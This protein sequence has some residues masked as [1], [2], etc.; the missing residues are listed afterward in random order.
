MSDGSPKARNSAYREQ[1]YVPI[2]WWVQATMFLAT[3]WIAFI[4]ATPAWVAWS[5]TA[6]SVFVTAAMLAN[7]GSARITVEGDV[8][9][10]GTARIDLRF[11]GEPEVLDAEQTRWAA[12]RD[13]DVRAYLL[14]RPYMKLSVRVPIN[15]PRDPAPYW[16]LGSRRPGQLAAVLAARAAALD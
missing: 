14:L 3:L 5:V 1:L 16:L 12:G 6:F 9:H 11:L 2:R 13:V 7:I 15:D 10:A 8:L 4:V